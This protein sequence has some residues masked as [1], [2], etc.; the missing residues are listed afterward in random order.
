[1]SYAN[2]VQTQLA[3][4]LSAVATTVDLVAA[5]APFVL[6]P[7]DGGT[8]VLV[9]SM[10]KPTYVEIIK[11]TSRTDNILS[12]ITRGQEGTTARVWPIGSYCYQ[13]LTAQGFDDVKLLIAAAAIVYQTPSDPGMVT[14]APGSADGAF[15]VFAG[16]GLY[17]YSAT[18][19]EIADG[20]V[21][22]GT[23]TGLGRWVQVAPHWD[24][25]WAY[26]APVFDDLQVQLAANSVAIAANTTAQT[27]IINTSA[28]LDFPNTEAFRAST[29]AATVAGAVVGASVIVTAPADLPSAFIVSGFVSSIGV[30]TVRM[31]NTSAYTINPASMAYPITVI[32]P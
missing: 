13:S 9:D 22:V 11:Y 6:P 21:V 16:M 1:M 27:K 15:A 4:S 31:S 17:E 5:V 28:V 12:G 25:V 23:T 20:E 24:F 2:F 32:N 7:T 3:G 26:L 18:S 14:F 19:T 10:G 29:L 8:L 30:V